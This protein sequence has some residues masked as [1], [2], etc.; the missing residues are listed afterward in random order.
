MPREP[1]RRKAGRKSYGD[2]QISAAPR[3]LRKG[4]AAH[5]DI[6]KELGMKKY[7]SERILTDWKQEEEK[8]ARR[9][10]DILV[11]NYRW[12]TISTKLSILA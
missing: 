10:S 4:F 5:S 8:K 7:G 3:S 11:D 2:V 9:I 12:T 1:I 6:A